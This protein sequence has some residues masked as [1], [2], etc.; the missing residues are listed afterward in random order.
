MALP[1]GIYTV[2]AIM[3]YK[4]PG[5]L[6]DIRITHHPEIRTVPEVI[7]CLWA[8]DRVAL[9]EQDTTPIRLPT[10]E[11]RIF[12]HLVHNNWPKPQCGWMTYSP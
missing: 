2:T 9:L 4:G 8:G 1:P 11:L 7:A 12:V 10:G 6:G 5:K 3:E